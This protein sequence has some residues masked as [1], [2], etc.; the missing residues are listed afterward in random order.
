MFIAA[1]L[2]HGLGV[3]LNPKIAECPPFYDPHFLIWLELHPLE[4]LLSVQSAP[5]ST[6][7][8]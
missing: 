3:F 8:T 4:S 2:L 7:L 6:G 5:D 1:D